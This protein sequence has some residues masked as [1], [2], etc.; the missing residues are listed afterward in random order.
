MLFYQSLLPDVYDFPWFN[1]FQRVKNLR[2]M[3]QDERELVLKSA[4]NHDCD[5]PAGRLF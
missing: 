2:N 4:N 1:G 5:I 3:W